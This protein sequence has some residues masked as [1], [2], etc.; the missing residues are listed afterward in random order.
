ML[1][2]LFGE[3]FRSFRDPFELS[4]VAADLPAET[5]RGVSILHPNESEEPFRVLRCL[6][7]F[8]ANASGK[9]TVLLA[10]DALRWMIQD[11]SRE[12]EPEKSIPKYTPFA[13]CDEARARPVILGCTIFRSGY[14]YEY[15]I[16]FTKNQIISEQLIRLDIPETPLLDRNLQTGVRGTLIKNSDQVKALVSTPKSNTP[17]FSF[18]AQH[19]PETGDSSVRPYWNAFRN[20]LRHQDYSSIGHA[21][22]FI[23][24]TAKRIHD[25]PK[26]GQWILSHLI[27][28]ADLG[29]CEI[30]SEEI[31]L[32]S[33]FPGAPEEFLKQ[34]A[35][36]A[37]YYRTAFIH[38]S[39]SDR[40]LDMD[41]E[42]SGTRK[43]YSL[44]SDWWNLAHNSRT[45][46]GD[47][48]SASLHPLLLDHLVRAVNQGNQEAGINSQL[49]FTTHDVGLMESRDSD[50]PALRRD[51]IYFTKKDKEGASSLY[52]L[53]E[54]KGEA[55]SVHN[56]R[57]R[58][59][60]D[61]YGAIPR[62]EELSL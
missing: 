62:I 40:I 61:R 1:I 13:F 18:L 38:G 14:F 6:G 46:F 36:N 33:I 59:L 42:S 50:P 8:G 10:A 57:K 44:A 23:D 49:A 11:S 39:S 31:E 60:E 15:K 19:G 9:S 28:P 25:Q 26:F 43:M 29:I 52:S 58:Y 47:E 22:Q 3:N 5:D 55:R 35:H 53:A 56:L 7:I 4:F 24:S 45:I 17:I 21:F 51:Q 54:F 30:K 27:R 34:I 12:L 16:T 32:Q 2:R 48:L 41:E 20:R 37:P